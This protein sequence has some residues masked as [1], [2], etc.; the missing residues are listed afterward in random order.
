MR[1]TLR[2]L[3]VWEEPGG[4]TPGDRGRPQGLR[5]L[6]RSLGTSQ[7]H[8]SQ[9]GRSS[10]L[11]GSWENPALPQAP[12]GGR[13]SRCPGGWDRRSWGPCAFPGAQERSSTPSPPGCP[14][15]HYVSLQHPPHSTGVNPGNGVCGCLA[16]PAPTPPLHCPL[17]PPGALRLPLSGRPRP[18]GAGP[19][20]Q[21]SAPPSTGSPV[22]NPPGCG[23]RPYSPAYSLP[24]ERRARAQSGAGSPHVI[25]SGPARPWAVG[26][27][28]HRTQQ[29]PF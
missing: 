29:T 24:W 2:G 3:R 27:G 20:L 17:P 5:P 13:L 4:G 14:P 8:S 23:H 22:D 1:E 9:K 26:E 25:G 16:P 6:A 18:L 21:A 28:P 7:R 19:V 10:G 12:G 11:P 15:T